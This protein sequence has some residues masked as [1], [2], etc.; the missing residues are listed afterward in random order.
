MVV[1]DGG[2]PHRIRFLRLHST[3]FSFFNF[4]N[5]LTLKTTCVSTRLRPPTT[6]RESSQPKSPTVSTVRIIKHLIIKCQVISVE[7]GER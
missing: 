6:T 3:S 1:G 2:R 7:W 4:F 5:V